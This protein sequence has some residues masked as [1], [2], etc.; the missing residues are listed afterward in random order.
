M[1]NMI[2]AS[3]DNNIIGNDNKLIWTLKDDLKRFKELTSGSTV[4]MGRKTYES[5]GKPL[6]N[7][8]NIVISRSKKVINGCI[9]VDSIEKAIKKADKRKQVFIIGGSQ[10]Y[11]LSINIVDTIY[12][13]KVHTEVEGDS[14]FFSEKAIKELGFKETSRQKF[15]KDERNEYPFSF[16]NYSKSNSI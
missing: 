7:R 6:P 12:L 5:I 13:T 2:V 8:I 4:I 9:V 14:K 15:D 10:I 16:I 3:S 1:I 11:D